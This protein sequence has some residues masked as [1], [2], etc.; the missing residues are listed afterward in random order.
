MNLAHCLSAPGYRWDTVLRFTD[1]N[2]K[3]IIGIKKYQ[4]VEWIMRG[5]TSIIYAGYSKANDK[6]FKLYDVIN[7]ASNII[8]LYANNLC[9]ISMIH[10]FPTYILEANPK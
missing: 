6:S 1:V 7:P 4:F 9:E 3:L 8:Y 10:L 5:G 2:L